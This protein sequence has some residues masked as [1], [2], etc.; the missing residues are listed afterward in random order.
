MTGSEE[1]GAAVRPHT[2]P[3]VTPTRGFVKGRTIAP[4]P[5]PGTRQSSSVTRSTYP[6]DAAVPENSLRERFLGIP[7]GGPAE[8]FARL[9]R[10]EVLRRDLVRRDGQ[11]LR[12]QIASDALLEQAYELEDRDRRLGREVERFTTD[13]RVAC[14]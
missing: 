10:R 7:A 1:P 2:L 9:C 3:N 11:D 5:P 12:V 13:C 8:E 14:H 6:P 4:T